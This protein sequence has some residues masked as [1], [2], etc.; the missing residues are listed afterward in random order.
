MKLI[1][2]VKKLYYDMRIR[3][4]FV[5]CL[6]TAIGFGTDALV[7][8]LFQRFTSTPAAIYQ[9]V[10]IWTGTLL[11]AI[12]S[13][14]WNKYFTFRSKKK[15]WR[16]IGRFAL[17]YIG[18]FLFSYLSQ[19]G[20]QAWL[21]YADASWAFYLVKLGVLVVQTLLSWFGQKYFSFR[22]GKNNDLTS[23][24]KDKE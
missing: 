3:F 12:N 14:F 16:E 15:S 23:E 17:V 2:L 21:G 10:A 11:G 19:M 6:N 8:F 22:K 5:G 1:D 20:L 7:C 24:E 13:Y 9:V 18:C 4:L